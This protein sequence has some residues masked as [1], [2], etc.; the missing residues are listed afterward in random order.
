MEVQTVENASRGKEAAIGVTT[1][2]SRVK[3]AKQQ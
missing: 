3:E 1:A 2:E